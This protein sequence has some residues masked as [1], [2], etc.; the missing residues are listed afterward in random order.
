MN[1]NSN[2]PPKTPQE[3]RLDRINRAFK[4]YDEHEAEGRSFEEYREDN[5]RKIVTQRLKDGE[6]FVD[7]QAVRQEL[8]D[9]EKAII[10]RIIKKTR[11]VRENAYNAYRDVLIDTE[12]A[13][14]Q[15]IVPLNEIEQRAQEEIDRIRKADKT[16][17][18]KIADSI[19]SLTQNKPSDEEGDN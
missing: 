4:Q 16:H 7:E 5:V 12:V 13:Q 8:I 11:Q 2:Q 17:L 6:I 9:K 10:E 19:N 3:N 14:A 15:G 18:R 1:D